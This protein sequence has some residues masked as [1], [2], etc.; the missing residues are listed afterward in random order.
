MRKLLSMKAM[1]L[2]LLFFSNNIL[3]AQSVLQN[4]SDKEMNKAVAELLSLTGTKK[5]ITVMMD[6]R[7][8]HFK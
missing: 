4:S 6:A 7:L 1:V 5:N 2:T 3:Y 8:K